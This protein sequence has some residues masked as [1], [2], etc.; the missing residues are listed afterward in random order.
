MIGGT[1]L[2]IKEK[3][4]Y[5]NF[6]SILCLNTLIDNLYDANRVSDVFGNY[7]VTTL[8]IIIAGWKV[9]YLWKIQLYSQCDENYCLTVTFVIETCGAFVLFE[10]HFLVTQ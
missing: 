3:K 10:T 7:I 1:H 9:Y 6:V 5:Q 4:I 2:K 8:I